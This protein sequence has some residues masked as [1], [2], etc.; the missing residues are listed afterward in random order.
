MK[1]KHGKL[2][3]IEGIDGSGKATVAA[4]LCSELLKQGEAVKFYSFPRYTKSMFAQE[5]GKVLDE[6]IH[7]PPFYKALPYA[8]DR[9]EMVEEIQQALEAGV[10]VVCDRYTLSN[11]VYYSGAV[12]SDAPTNLRIL[13]MSKMLHIED[14]LGVIEPDINIVLDLSVSLAQENILRKAQRSYTGAAMD[15]NESDG[16]FLNTCRE[17]YKIAAKHYSHTQLVEVAYEGYLRPIEDIT[18][19][20][21]NLINNAEI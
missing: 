17:I 15:A 21:L 6:G 9:R 5:A 10:Y 2:I 12:S 20:V 4:A 1:T 7:V 14:T 16:A 3:A 11:A 8:L 19:E 13:R 18:K